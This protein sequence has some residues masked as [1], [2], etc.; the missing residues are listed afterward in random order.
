MTK[1]KKI[2]KKT[3][4]KKKKWIVQGITIYADTM[5]EAVKK[6]GELG[7]PDGI[8]IRKKEPEKEPKKK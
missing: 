5:K 3:E 2:E 6:W 8:K 1:T 4:K 7:M